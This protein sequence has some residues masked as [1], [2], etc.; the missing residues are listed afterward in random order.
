MPS[1][2]G[3]GQKID[4]SK[5]KVRFSGEGS[6]LKKKSNNSHKKSVL[7][8][9]KSGS[10]EKW[11]RSTPSPTSAT[12]I[13]CHPELVSGSDHRKTIGITQKENVVASNMGQMPKRVRHDKEKKAAFTLAEVLI[14]LG[15]IG[16]VA[17]MT[18][19]TLIQNY[20]KQVILTQ[21]KKNYAILNQAVQLMKANYDGIDPV[22]MPFVRQ[23]WDHPTYLDGSLF[24]PEFAKYLPTDWHQSDTSGL[25]CF[26]DAASFNYKTRDGG[27]MASATWHNTG[28]ANDYVWHLTNGA[29]IT[30]AYGRNWDWDGSELNA[31]TF[32]IDVNGS[33]KNPN[34]IGKDLF[35]FHFMPDGRIIPAG[36]EL[37]LSEMRSHWCR[38]SNSG[39]FCAA[40]IVA[41]GWQFPKDYP[42]KW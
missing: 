27:N 42:I 26:K 18:L 14:T 4:L 37:T 12:P 17:A 7:S 22:Q 20:Q 15:I 11:T 23:Q 5:A 8:S 19:P 31:R 28:P 39:E 24:G 29:C 6:N 9:G 13:L 38:C 21:L 34:Q 1:T 16:V 30:F 32:V 33:D 2:I 35:F 41:N 36:N 40:E 3:R 10:I 25:G